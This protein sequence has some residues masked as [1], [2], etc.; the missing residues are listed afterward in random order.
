MRGKVLFVVGLGVGYV[1]GTRAG[2]ERYEQIK[3]AAEGVWNTPAVQQ[4]V[5]T[6]KDFAATRV[7]DLSDT[8][9]D[10]VKTLHRQQRA[11]HGCHEVRR[12]QRIEVGERGRR[13]ERSGRE[14]RGRHR[15][16][17]ARRRDRPGR[18]DCGRRGETRVEARHEAQHA[19]RLEAR[20][21]RLLKPEVIRWPHRRTTSARS[22]R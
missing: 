1:L 21:I 5:G 9:L 16:R 17:R 19:A 4:G 13:E 11:R 2:R 7:G 14:V 22:S 10:G 3:K 15:G 8:V 6:V 20:G 18:R 12:R